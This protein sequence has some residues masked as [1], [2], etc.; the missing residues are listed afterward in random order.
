MIEKTVLENLGIM[1]F[2][3]FCMGLSFWWFLALINKRSGIKLKPV[4]EKIY[5]NP[6]AAAVYRGAML[7]AVSMLV[8]AAYTRWV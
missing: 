8:I 3:L 6:L 5:E 2:L 1:F 7:I 4:L